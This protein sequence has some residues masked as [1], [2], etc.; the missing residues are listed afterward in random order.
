MRLDPRGEP[1][2]RELAARDPRLRQ[3]GGIAAAAYAETAPNPEMHAADLDAAVAP[4]RAWSSRKDGED[5]AALRTEMQQ[6]MD[7]SRRDLPQ[8]GRPPGGIEA[9]P[10][11]QGAVPPGTVVDQSKVYNLNLSDALEVGHM[12]TLAETIV[13]G[14]YSSNRTK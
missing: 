5:P 1:P 3:G 13:V 14:A 10:R 4:L 11:D 6:A 2:R 9:D 7:Q 12:L 8:R